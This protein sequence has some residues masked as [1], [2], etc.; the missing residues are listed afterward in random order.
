MTDAMR[1]VLA[2]SLPAV[3]A[4]CSGPVDPIEEQIA[5]DGS[6]GMAASTQS[7][8][9]AGVVFDGVSVADPAE[10]AG[11]LGAPGQL[12][13][14]GCV[15]RARDAVEPD[16]VHVTFADCSGPFGLLDI[17]GEVTVTL[18]AGPA[19]ALH[20]A[21]AGLGLTAGGGPVT[22]SATADTTFPTLTMR[23]VVWQE[24]WLRT[25][26][27]GELVT[28]DSDVT[29]AVDTLAGC[30]TLDGSART[31][32]AD[33]QVDSTLRGYRICHDLTGAEGCPSGSVIH[34]GEPSGKVVTIAYD[35]SDTAH[36]T[37]PKGDTFEVALGCASIGR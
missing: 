29:L 36:V 5:A 34:T 12:W 17:D 15:T 14:S 33:R 26:A 28:H 18:S 13:P 19:G 16:V 37:G 20:V 7:T 2:F 8:S 32:V 25:D 31:T 10:A 9:L 22:F 23:E 3:L 35:A 24:T 11:Q 6:E 30:R 1:A 4:A 27:A 21:F